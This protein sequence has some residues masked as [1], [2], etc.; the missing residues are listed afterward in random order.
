M[1]SPR[2][3]ATEKTREAHLEMLEEER[4]LRAEK[5]AEKADDPDWVIQTTGENATRWLKRMENTGKQLAASL[6]S[7]ENSWK[8]RMEK[9]F[10]GDGQELMQKKL[11]AIFEK[12]NADVPDP[13]TG[14]SLD[15]PYLEK[16]FIRVKGVP[17]GIPNY[18]ISRAIYKDA[19][20]INEALRTPGITQ[21]QRD[22]LMEMGRTLETYA[23]NDRERMAKEMYTN[24]R[25]NNYTDN[26][27]RQMGKV[28]IIIV[29]A[30]AA[31]LTGAM[32]IAKGKFSI[33]PLLYAGIA[34][35]LASPDL[36][37]SVFGGEHQTALSQLAES[38]QSDEFKEEDK[39]YHIEGP[40]WSAVV[41]DVTTP[42]IQ[43]AA[44]IGKMKDGTATQIEK[45]AYAS[46]MI[47]DTNSDARKD[48]QRMLADP[49]DFVRFAKRMQKMTD[50]DARKA[51]NYFVSLNRS[52]FK[53]QF[54]QKVE[55]MEDAQRQ[56]EVGNA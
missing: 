32:S 36:R 45:D 5:I 31:L 33:T 2:E 47:G 1:H 7:G 3:S 43:T 44:F 23:M 49:K 52:A 26:A 4:T 21:Q 56:N 54:R 50:P 17:G 48:L 29:A 42:D 16:R 9:A 37:K 28:G 24:A 10:E 55:N 41:K 13:D 18:G 25:G 11:D 34:A 38:V 53:R 20:F 19:E 6:N 22:V 12:L 46:R 40:G 8:N 39:K 27:I 30:A 51:G 15:H 35:F 14:R